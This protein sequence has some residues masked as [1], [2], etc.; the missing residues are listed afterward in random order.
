MGIKNVK[1]EENVWW[2]LSKIK[3]NNKLKSISEVISF[4]LKKFE[5]KK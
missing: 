4:L 2:K 5:G 3:V 1:V